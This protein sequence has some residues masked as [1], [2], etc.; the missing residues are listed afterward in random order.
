MPREME[1]SAS[2]G[3]LRFKS[4]YIFCSRLP[5]TEWIGG[6]GAM[7]LVITSSGKSS[8]GCIACP[9]RFIACNVHSRDASDLNP[10]PKVILEIAVAVATQLRTYRY[11]VKNGLHRYYVSVAVGYPEVPAIIE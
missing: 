4:S 5:K 9:M 3:E 1:P 10:L 2:F 8:S 7:A 6:S 11:R